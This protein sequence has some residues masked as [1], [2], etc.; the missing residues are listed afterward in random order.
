MAR[1]VVEVDEK[2]H[3]FNSRLMNSANSRSAM[4]SEPATVPTSGTKVPSPMF[5]SSNLRSDSGQ[6][7]QNR[8][9]FVDSEELVH[10]RQLLPTGQ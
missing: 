10:V 9:S 7:P 8:D 1:L 3:P 6:A 4:R 2:A 5:S